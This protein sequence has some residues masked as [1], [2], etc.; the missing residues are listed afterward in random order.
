ME[1]KRGQLLGKKKGWHVL[2]QRGFSLIELMIAFVVLGILLFVGVDAYRIWIQNTQIRTA[3]EAALNGMQLARGE[4]VRRNAN[5]QMVLAGSGWTVSVPSTGEQIQARSGAEGS[6][7]VVVTTAPAGSTTITFN[8]LGRVIAN[9]DATSSIT[10]VDVDSSVLPASE[11]RELRIMVGIGGDV[12]M[13]DPQLAA[14]DP[15]AC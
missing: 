3:A 4:A 14:P 1:R 2:T 7:N 10:R 15:R 12:R 8:G 6:S 5:V 9:A 13:C 11:S